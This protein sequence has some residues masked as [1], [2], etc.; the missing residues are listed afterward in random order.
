MIEQYRE[1]QS[2][3]NTRQTC[4]SF[5][6]ECDCGRSGIGSKTGTEL[7]VK[8]G[9]ISFCHTVYSHLPSGG[10]FC[11]LCQGIAEDSNLG[12]VPLE[13]LPAQVTG[14]FPLS[15]PGTWPPRESH[16][17]ASRPVGTASRRYCIA[18]PRRLCGPCSSGRWQR[19]ACNRPDQSFLL[20][21][22]LD[23]H[24]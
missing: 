5:V 13:V 15:T 8:L 2:P 4:F 3:I 19:W 10:A 9:V 23:W 22:C 11:G 16:R 20:L 17:C 12:P 1:P 21:A 6:T 7:G 18:G 14:R 24:V